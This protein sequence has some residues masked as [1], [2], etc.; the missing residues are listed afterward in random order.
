MALSPAQRSALFEA[1]E[2]RSWF[3]RESFIYA[4]NQTM[5]LL[6]A[7]PWQADLAEFHE[8]MAG[9]KERII[10]NAGFHDNQEQHKNVVSDIT[11]LI[12]SI[13]SLLPPV[14]VN[15]DIV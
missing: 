15:E 12:E 1:L 13:E 11:S 7:E 10:K 4:P 9:R 2:S 6:V 8:R 5:W 14:A 3:Y